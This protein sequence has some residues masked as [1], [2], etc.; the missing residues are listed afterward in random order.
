MGVFIDKQAILAAMDELDAGRLYFIDRQTGKISLL[1]VADK[2]GLE[3]M[4]KLLKTE[5]HRYTQIPRPEAREN[6]TELEKFIEQM[7]DPKFKEILKRTLVSHRPFR[8]FRDLIHN[9]PKEKRE[10]DAYHKKNM[11]ARLATFLKSA[12]LVP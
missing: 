10:W 3:R 11:E 5:P 6:F 8:E 9:R 4:G 2:A 12:G 7:V 1:T